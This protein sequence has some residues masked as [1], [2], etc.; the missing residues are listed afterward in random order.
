[1]LFGANAPRRAGLVHRELWKTV[2]WHTDRCCVPH[3][4]GRNRE[5]DALGIAPYAG[6]RHAHFGFGS[7]ANI[8][9]VNV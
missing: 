2:F 1:M 8:G 9:S 3:L 4:L 5:P 7:Q 6:R